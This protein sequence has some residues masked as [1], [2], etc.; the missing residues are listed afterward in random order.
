MQTLKPDT[1]K[2]ILCVSKKLFLQHGYRDTTTRDIAREAGVGLSNLYHY[3]ASKD[4]LFTQLLK[5]AP[6]FAEAAAL[7]VAGFLPGGVQGV[8]C[9]QGHSPGAGL[10]PGDEG[11]ASRDERRR[12]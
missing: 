4:E 3:Y 5:P 12:V 6:E 10:V 2:R 7:Q 8:L 1:R 9:Q 11:E